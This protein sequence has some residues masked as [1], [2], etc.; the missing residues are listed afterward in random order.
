M[1]DLLRSLTIRKAKAKDLRNILTKENFVFGSNDV[2]TLLEGN[3]KGVRYGN[4]VLIRRE[5]GQE[6][7]RFFKVML[8][9]KLRTFKL[10]RRQVEVSRVLHKYGK[11]PYL[12]IQVRGYSLISPV[13]YGIFETRESGDGFG[14]MHDRPEYYRGLSEIDIEN[15][16]QSIYAFHKAGDDIYAE[17][18][19]YVRE[20][21]ASLSLYE[22]E[23]LKNLHKKITYQS[24]LGVM[25]EGR[26][27]E[28]VEKL[29]GFKGIE[30]KILEIFRTNWWSVEE[31]RSKKKK[32]LVHGDLSI[33][34]LYKHRNGTFEPIDFEWVGVADNLV[35]AIM[36]DYGNLRARAWSAPQ[37][38]ET[39]D[40]KM[41]EVG[42]KYGVEQ[43]VIEAA[44]ILGKLSMGVPFCRFHLDFLNTVRK[45]K[46]TEQDYHEMSSRTL[47]SLRTVLKL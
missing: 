26:V 6:I 35:V 19:P 43:K 23:I 3:Q 34:N 7:K 16:V 9:G 13:P 4:I 1:L 5:A 46:H 12:T 30:G 47:E 33:D 45:D 22:K 38:Q 20:S 10:F 29:L 25:V 32:Y 41:F 21:S 28:F 27:S 37:F 40:K 42:K 11:L 44:L 8:D 39:L 15:I 14:F 24:P 36:T 17:I 18:R 2:Q 31:S